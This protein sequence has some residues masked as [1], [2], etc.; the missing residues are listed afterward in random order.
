MTAAYA[1]NTTTQSVALHLAFELGLSHWRLSFT[2]GHGQKP[3]QR[4]IRARDLA[5]LEQEIIK[6]KKRFKLNPD[7]PV[8][9][10]YEAGRDG[11]WLRRYLTTH[12]IGKVIVDSSSIGARLGSETFRDMRTVA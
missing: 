10:C 11:F 12:G 4:R 2:T 1:S 7:A 8:L 3:R 5:A 6:A 9:S